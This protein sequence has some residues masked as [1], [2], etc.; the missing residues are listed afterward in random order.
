MAD[1]KT[2]KVGDIVAIR[3]SSIDATAYDLKAQVLDVLPGGL[4]IV[5]LSTQKAGF[6]LDGSWRKVEE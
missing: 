6:V 1:I 3:T 2:V 5:Y 4:E